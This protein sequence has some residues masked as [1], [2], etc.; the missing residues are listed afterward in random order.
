MPGAGKL[1]KKWIPALSVL[2]FLLGTVGYV[3]A[4]ERVLDAMYFS[5]SL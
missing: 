1:L 2:P 4:G 5:F 3:L